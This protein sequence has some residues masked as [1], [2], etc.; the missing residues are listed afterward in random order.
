[1]AEF[2]PFRFYDPLRRKWLRARYLAERQTIAARYDER[3][4]T[5]P[6]EIRNGVKLEPPNSPLRRPPPRT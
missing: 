4:I 1:M 6:P 2:F 5:G 3:E